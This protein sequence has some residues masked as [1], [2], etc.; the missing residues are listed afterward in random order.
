MELRHL[1]WTH[2]A[3][4][5]LYHLHPDV[6]VMDCT[7]KTNKYK[8]PLLNIVTVTG[9]NKVLPVAQ[10]WLPGG[11]EADFVLAQ[12]TLWQL[13]I[14]KDIAPPGVIVTDRDLAFMN[15]VD[16]VFA[17]IPAMV[18]RWHMNKN[19][20]ARTRHVL[21]QVPVQLPAPGQPKYENLWQTNAFLAA[22]YK[23]IEARADVEFEQKR[24]ALASMSPSLSEYLDAHW[25]K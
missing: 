21:G 22:F 24:I 16:R 13:M 3:T 12:K 23:A 14:E 7:Y 4:S 8:L 5:Q 10:Y 25:W 1:F 17:G 19:V 20:V 2:P 9:F 15:A 11:T 6:L 18:C